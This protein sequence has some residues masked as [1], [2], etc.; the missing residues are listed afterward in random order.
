M[1]WSSSAPEHWW[2]WAELE[3][4]VLDTQVGGSQWVAAG[5]KPGQEQSSAQGQPLL[6]PLCSHGRS[7]SR[8]SSLKHSS[9]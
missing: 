6:W 4:H 5:E 7:S 2:D 1:E 8:R 9:N 3:M